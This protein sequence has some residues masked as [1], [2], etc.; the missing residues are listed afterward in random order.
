MLVENNS[1]WETLDHFSWFWENSTGSMKMCN[2]QRPNKVA[3]TVTGTGLPGS[4]SETLEGLF[5]KQGSFL[6]HRCCSNLAWSRFPW[7]SSSACRFLAEITG[8]SSKK[9]IHLTDDPLRH[10]GQTACLLCI[11]AV[12]PSKHFTSCVFRS[13]QQV[14]LQSIS[15]IDQW[16][17]INYN[18]NKFPHPG[19]SA[20]VLG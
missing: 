14:S 11:L 13:S 9:E 20:I 8:D 16:P 18:F 17:K 3:S 6:E 1:E 5:S 10:S 2:T 15:I 19:S 4:A 7:S 12:R